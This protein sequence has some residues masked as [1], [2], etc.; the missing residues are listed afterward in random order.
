MN[1]TLLDPMRQQEARPPFVS[2]RLRH[3]RRRLARGRLYRAVCKVL[4]QGQ[5]L[6][7][8]RLS[9]PPLSSSSQP[10]GTV[11][12]IAKNPE[13]GQGVKTELPM[14]IAEELDVDWKDVKIEQADLDETKYGP[15][16][17]GGSTATPINW[18]PLRQVGAAMRS[19]FVSAGAQEWNVEEAELSTASGRVIHQRTNRSAL[20]RRTGCESCGDDS[21]GAP[22]GQAEGPEGLQ[23][24]RPAH[25]RRR[26]SV[27]R[28]RQAD[29]QHRLHRPEHALGGLRKVPCVR[30]KSGE[31]QS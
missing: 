24:H 7:R 26:R 25:S 14:I 10:D 20:L 6:A 13:I 23:N 4:A 28:P 30:R 8:R 11:T 31:R 17:A 12:I 9:C 1:T 22:R 18:D 21:A 19:M 5:P 2:A 16:R 29:L 3:R 27:H 15:Q